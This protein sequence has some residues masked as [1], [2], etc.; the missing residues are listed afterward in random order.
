MSKSANETTPGPKA[1]EKTAASAGVIRGTEVTPGKDEALAAIAKGYALE[2]E[3][4]Y[5]MKA[6]N[7]AGTDAGHWFYQLAYNECSIAI[8]ADG[9]RAYLATASKLASLPKLSSLLQTCGFTAIL[10]FSAEQVRSSVMTG[11]EWLLIAEGRPSVTR[12]G[13]DFV[14]PGDAQTEIPEPALE[15]LSRELK[16]LVESGR[17]K[18]SQARACRGY[19]TLPGELV[20]RVET[21]REPVEGRDIFGRK[22]LEE[23]H[24]VRPRAGRWVEEHEDRFTAERYGYMCLLNGE[25]SILPPIHL[26]ADG[27]LVSW[28]LLDG[29]RHS[30]DSGLLAPWLE[31]MNLEKSVGSGVIGKLAPQVAEGTHDT[32]AYAIAKGTPP[33]HGANAKVDVL[34]DLKERAGKVQEDG[35]TDFR[36][37]NFAPNA[38]SGQRILLIHPPTKG[39]DGRNVWGKV[40]AARDGTDVDLRAGANVQVEEDGKGGRIYLATAD[41]GLK[42]V[43]EEVAVV[44]TLV[45]EGSVGFDTGNLQFAGEIIVKGNVGQGFTVKAGA[46][47]TVCGSIDAG[48]VVAAGG[49]IAVGYGILGRK[50]KV[51]AVG[52]VRAQFV[53]EARVRAGHNLRLYNHAQNALLQAGHRIIIDRSKGPR[54]GSLAGGEAWG[55]HGIRCHFAGSP[56]YGRTEMVSGV[57]PQQAEKLDMLNRKLEESQKLLMRQLER[58]GL[59]SVDVKAIQRRLAASSGTQQRMLSRAAH[60]LGQVAQ[61]HQ[62]LLREKMEVEKSMTS[63]LKGAAIE[64]SERAFPGVSIRIGDQQHRLKIDVENARFH[65]ANDQLQER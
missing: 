40:V 46:D 57:D 29:R 1:E 34:I 41:G 17:I 56:T 51:V 43:R 30:V 15:T 27:M 53:Q 42:L 26:D 20:A 44:D 48:S 62:G 36:E 65:I 45:I 23:P 18:N 24:F 50:T 52:D 55:L 21:D 59:K 61:Q 54:G 2:I 6:G 5:R 9:M 64:A 39:T 47:I 14:L 12:E 25:L 33:Q 63:S 19:A 49:N 22:L 10:P 8:R 32:G 3:S 4:A 7:E 28:L 38:L 60:Q 37:T 16:A 58:F 11:N 35:A 31:E 13:A